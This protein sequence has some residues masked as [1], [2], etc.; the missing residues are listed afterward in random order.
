[1]I[2]HLSKLTIKTGDVLVCKDFETLRYLSTV[3]VPGISGTTPLVF[4]PNGVQSLTRQDLLNLLEQLDQAEVSAP[5]TDS[6][7]IPL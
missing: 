7:R 2:S 3:Q 5:L 1:M 6:P 4:A